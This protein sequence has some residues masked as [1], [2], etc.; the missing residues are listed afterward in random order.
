[1]GSGTHDDPYRA[2]IPAPVLATPGFR[3][4]A[5]IPTDANGQP[6]FADCYVWIPDSFPI[7]PG[8]VVIPSESARGNINARDPKCNPG[9]MEF[10]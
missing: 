8:L 3:Y 9:G 2:N 7:P 6:L 5:H 10:V 4:S 1:M